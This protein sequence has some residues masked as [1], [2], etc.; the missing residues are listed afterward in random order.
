[1]VGTVSVILTTHEW[2][3]VGHYRD[4]IRSVEEQTYPDV[5]LVCPVDGDPDIAQCTEALADGGVVVEYYGDGGL[6]AARNRGARLA[7]GDVYAFLDDDCRAPPGWIAALVDVLEDGALAAGGPAVPAW[8]DGDRPWYLPQLFDWLVGCG[9]YYESQRTVRNT[10]GCNLAVCAD[11]FDA[12][13]GF[14]DMLGK[15]SNLQ[16]AEETELCQR[17]RERYGG[18]VEYVPEAHVSHRVAAEQLRLSYLLRR[19]YMQG[20]AKAHIGVDRE[21]SAFLKT[22]LDELTAGA[23]HPGTAASLGLYTAAVGCGFLRGQMGGLA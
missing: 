8:P 9:P 1:M 20:R 12:L 3:R 19:A 14:D 10:Y 22:V 15:Q 4:A 18:G 2:S 7:S 21:E 11:I 6:A 23:R 13:D 17:L 16:Q 5:E